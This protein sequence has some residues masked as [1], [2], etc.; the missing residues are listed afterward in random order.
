MFFLW[1]VTLIVFSPML[2]G[3]FTALDDPG[4][5]LENPQVISLAPE[6]ITAI[7]RTT[8]N[9]TYI[10]LTV[11]SFAVEHHFFGFRPFV[12]HW[13]N[14]LLHMFVVGLLFGLGRRMGLSAPAAGAGSLLFAVHP[15]H[16]ESVAWVTERKDVLYAFFYML[17]LYQ[18]CRYLQGGTGRAFIFSVVFGFLSILAKPMALSLPVVLCLFDLFYGRKFSGRWLAE[19]LVH[20]AYIIP[21]AWITASLHQRRLMDNW[22]EAAL[23]AAWSFVFYIRKFIYPVDLSPLYA[24]PS[25]VSL[26]NPEILFSVIL[27]AGYAACLARYRGNRWF[28][29]ANGFFIASI[30]FLVRLRSSWGLH[31]VADRFMYLPSAGF[32]LL[33]GLGVERLFLRAGARKAANVVLAVALALLFLVLGA[34]TYRQTQVWENDTTLWAAVI[35]KGATDRLAYFARGKMYDEKGDHVNAVADYTMAITLDPQFPRAY[36]NRGIIYGKRGDYPR[37]LADFNRALALYPAFAQAYNNRGLIYFY[38]RE[39]RLALEDFNKAIELRPRV[40]SSYV[41]R[42]RLFQVTGQYRLA[43][44]DFTRALQLEPGSAVIAEERAEIYRALEGVVK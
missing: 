30:F 23:T 21:V 44:V 42:A 8:V 3:Q 37:A 4:H 27:F 5:L 16:V 7:F 20:A 6:N 39:D 40:A 36:N 43:A 31:E 28:F 41:N 32:C 35:R 14:L 13:D 11:L 24:T 29:F 1:A 9:D 19:K 12:Y 26:E 15:M 25:P 38:L 2:A 34:Q 22:A 33:L 17:A 10:P 18:Y